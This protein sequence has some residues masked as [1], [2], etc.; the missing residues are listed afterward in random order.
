MEIRAWLHPK[1]TIPLILSKLHDVYAVPL[2]RQQP[3]FAAVQ[4]LGR[5]FF[6]ISHLHSRH[7][8][9]YQSPQLP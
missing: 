4:L 9:Q 6:A 8:A 2:N 3:H 1:H 5:A 7:Q